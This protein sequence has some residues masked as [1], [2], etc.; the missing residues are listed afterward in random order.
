MT[1]QIQVFTNEELGSLRTVEIDGEIYFVAADVAKILGIEN[2]RQNIAD[3]S[4]DEKADVCITCTSSNGV[5][6]K[7]KVW[8]VNE[9]GLYRLIFQSRKPEAKKF[10]RWIFHEVLPSIRKTGS[11]STKNESNEIS[12]ERKVEL[13]IEMSKITDTKPLQDSIIQRAFEIVT[14]EKSNPQKNNRYDVKSLEKF[15]KNW[16]AKNYFHIA[17]RNG[18]LPPL[19]PERGFYHKGKVCIYPVEEFLKDAEEEGFTN[20]DELLNSLLKNSLFVP[21]RAGEGKHRR[22]KCFRRNGGWIYGLML[23]KI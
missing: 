13:L 21:E 5:T 20:A 8:C 19:E 15:L 4:D 16:L 6:Q 18:A 23:N 2:I 22:K 10:Q 17:E 3:F 14:G 9:P 1:K 12:P 11:Y 7:R